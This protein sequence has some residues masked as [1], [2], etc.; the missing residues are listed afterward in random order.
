M[1]SN[2]SGKEPIVIDGSYGEGGGQILRTSVTLSAVMGMPIEIVNIRAK[3]DNPGLRPQHVGA[4]KAISSLCNA[5]V[6]NL[7]VGSDRIVFSP[8]RLRSTF[9]RLDVGSAGSVTLL[10]QAIIPSVSLSRVEA[11][12]EIIGG[13]DVK[14]S[15]TMNYFTH[16]VLPAYRLLG[17]EANLL[18]KRRGYYPVGGGIVRVGIKPAREL[19]PLNIVS[20]EKLLPSIISICS[21]LPRGVAE[22][23]MKA[24]KD[25]LSNRGINPKSFE[26]NIDDSISPGSSILVYSVGDKGPFI[27]SG[28]IGERGKPSEE[29]GREAA[30]IFSEEYNSNAPMDRH[31]GDM[32]VPFLPFAK[33]ESIFRVSKVTQHLSTNLHIASIFTKCQYSID[34]APDGTA[35]VSVKNP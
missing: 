11:E 27:G 24:A 10:L 29:V 35:I 15:P 9:I 17:I 23:Q 6:E 2:G 4:I 18:V 33:G 34:E 14:W 26:I 7:R 22:R 30:K 31:V 8:N 1:I 16:V 3:R 19:N 25:Y 13:T 28:T 20:L 32:L 21:R 5:S 12:L